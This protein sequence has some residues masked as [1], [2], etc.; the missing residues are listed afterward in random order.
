MKNKLSKVFYLLSL[1]AMP[2]LV[3]AED[4]SDYGVLEAL[5]MH[6][7]L[8][9]HSAGFLCLP[10][11]LFFGSTPV[12]QKKAFWKTF[13]IRAIV[14]VVL[15]FVSPGMSIFLDVTSIFIGGFIGFPVAGIF[16]AIKGKNNKGTVTTTR[17]VNQVEAKCTNCG[18]PIK[19]GQAFCTECGLKIPVTSIGAAVVNQTVA[20]LPS[21]SQGKPLGAANIF[22]YNMTEEQMIEEI[23]KREMKKSGETNNVSIAAVEKKKNIFS[24]VYAIIL[25]ICV[26]LF[27]FHSYTGVLVVVFLI[28]TIIYINSVKN[29]NIYKYLQKEI[30]A[31]PDEKIGYIVS[32]V[33]E[34]KVGGS[35]KLIRLAFLL[36]A[37]CVPLFIFRTPHVIYEQDDTLEGYVVRFYTIGWLNND[38]T[39]EIP[40]EYNGEPVV[41]IRG[42]VFANVK[43]IEK[44]VLPDTIK[45]IR[46]G[47]FKNASNLEEINLPEGIPEIKGETFQN[48]SN[49]KEITIPDSVTRI[50]GHAFRENYSL[51]KVNIGPN[52]QLTEIGSS[53][54]RDCYELD[55]IYLPRDVNIDERS[56]KGSGTNVKEYTEDGIVLQD[57]YKYDT[58]VYLQVGEKKEINQYHSDAITQG[59]SVKLDKVEGD[60]GDYTF[61][62]SI[63]KD[64][65]GAR[66]FP[67]YRGTSYYAVKDYGIAVEITNDYVFDSYDDRVSLNIYYN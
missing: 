1:V 31:R 61:V 25:F 47:A 11:S 46:G 62:I 53:A 43:T 42:D 22:G 45:E 39:L 50:G 18:N 26:S 48:C 24:I 4:F 30:K 58:Y 51:T 16:T 55:E 21:A 7:G 23:I 8:T 63:L 34:G 19:P 6:L 9:L 12:L 54:F 29:Y 17:K 66:G 35:S 14:V 59:Y 20:S 13:W 32:T 2:V 41:G 49:L 37:V 56:F 15:S 36:V 64:G 40:A 10:V 65:G 60:Y 38:T 44:V 5:L 67:L 33:L 27:F 52:S 28:A 3:L 57:E